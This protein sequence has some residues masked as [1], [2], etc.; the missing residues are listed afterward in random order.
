MSFKHENLENLK[1]GERVQ[2]IKYDNLSNYSTFPG[3]IDSLLSID[4]SS[5]SMEELSKSLTE[6]YELLEMYLTKDA[7][8]NQKV[9]DFKRLTT[10]ISEYTLTSEDYI[11]LRDSLIELQNY[12]KLIT[13]QELYSETGVY[14]SLQK[15]ARNFT[16]QLNDIIK[17]INTKYSNLPKGD[18][19]RVI[20]DGAINENYLSEDLKKD[21][22]YISMTTGI[23]IDRTPGETISVPAEIKGKATVIKLHVS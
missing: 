5:I 22:N 3:S 8:F 13:Q 14:T 18:V 21:F 19:G 12:L 10:K 17:E 4:F 11:I 23:Y 6:Y 1:V 20:P 16:T 9:E 2:N 15:S 7:R